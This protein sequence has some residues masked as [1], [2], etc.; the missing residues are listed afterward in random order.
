MKQCKAR[1][2]KTYRFPIALAADHRLTAYLSRSAIDG[3][4]DHASHTG[5]SC[6][7]CA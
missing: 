1:R 7:D 4:L 5:F 2:L 6:E 3:L